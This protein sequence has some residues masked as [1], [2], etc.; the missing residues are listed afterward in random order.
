MPFIRVSARKSAQRRSRVRGRHVGR[1][2]G[3]RSRRSR[4]SEGRSPVQST[5]AYNVEVAARY[6]AGFEAAYKEGVQAGLQ[7]FAIPFEG[8]SIVIP[9]Y[10]QLGFL[11]PCIES[12]IANTGAPY[13]I[14]VVDNAS[15][16]GTA[17][18]LRSLG[19]Q[20]RFRVLETNRGFA[21]GTNVGLMM[22]KGTTMMLLNNDTLVTPNWLENMLACLH[23][24]V[25]IGMVGPVTNFISGSQQV[26]VPY[27][28]PKHMPPFAAANNISNPAR[29]RRTDRLVGFCV[30][31]RR[32]LF[33]AV[34]Y[35]DEGFLIGNFEDE[36]FNVR[37]R[38]LGRTL[39]VAED[40]FIHHHGSVSM[41]ELGDRMM[42][43]NNRNEQYY[44]QKWGYPDEAVQRVLQHPISQGGPLPGA[45][46]VYPDR[47]AVQGVGP[48]VYWI[49]GG[50]RRLVNGAVNV[51]VTRMSQVDLRRWP[52]G[53]VISVE[54]VAHRW[55]GADHEWLA[56]V[57]VLPDGAA[58]HLEGTHI[59]RIW[60]PQ[61][62]ELWKLHLK[63]RRA[64]APEDI[65]SM[66]EGLPIVAPPQLL[67]VL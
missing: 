27:E 37:V 51:P 10:N 22:A 7:R 62:M 23:S 2:R 35:L 3:R 64:V 41:K 12:I 33:E 16:D 19:G 4:G 28:H 61:A 24:D 54:E 36:D 57:V 55:H 43:V 65:A 46:W 25:K 67:Q 6:N 34:G 9:T 18:Y 42:E 5:A 32:E 53:D 50:K 59:R 11:R 47:V 56:S 20:V 66:V 60:G 40:S 45:A 31:F 26:A 52:L 15:T 14:I 48:L 44:G 1:L 8:T 38:M 21:G 58:F 17:D 63:P 49:E 39:M 30:L 13:E 29:W